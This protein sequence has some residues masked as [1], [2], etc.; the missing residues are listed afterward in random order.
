MLEFERRVTATL[1][2]IDDPG[3]RTE[4]ERFVSGSLGDMPEHLRAGVLVQSVAFGVWARARPR[5]ATSHFVS[6]LEASRVPLLRQYVRLFR[7]LVLF[8]EQELG[9]T[10]KLGYTEE[11]AR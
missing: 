11:A 5:S 9:Y 7:S 8:A 1:M 10:E 4:V 6:T 2:T 3:T